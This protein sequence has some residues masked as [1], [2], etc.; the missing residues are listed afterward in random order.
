MPRPARCTLLSLFLLLLPSG[1]LTAPLDF[2]R[3][4]AARK[5]LLQSRPRQEVE[6]LLKSVSQAELIALGRSAVRELGVY[7]ARL[8]KQE[9]V[10]GQLQAAQVSL[11]TVREA[12]YAVRMEVIEGPK[13][14]RKVLYNEQLRKGELRVREA[15][16]LGL[17]ALWLDLDSSL[18]RRD[19]H[20]PVT[21]LGFG[22]ILRHLAQD[23]A[24]AAPLGA[25]RR[26][27]EGF[28]AR[29]RWCLTFVAPAGAQKLHALRTR[30][31]LDLLLGLPVELEAHDAQGLLERVELSDVR[32]N[33]SP[34]P[35]HFS[36]EA[37]G[38]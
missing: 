11:I 23:Q 15:G 32:A 28:D 10:Q 31:C 16:L 14:G 1:A 36:P 26:Q 17:K 24:L 21:D 20:H 5:A 38:L 3:T 18:A 4:Q 35:D 25:H 37:M 30:M 27:D 8:R 22:P 9:R 19:T 13:K 12:P 2:P 29:G 7:S 33:L 6:V 34:P